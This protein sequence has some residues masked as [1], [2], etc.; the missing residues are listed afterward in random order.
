MDLFLVHCL[1]LFWISLASAR[2][3]AARPADQLLAAGLLAWGNVV[4]T[5]LLLAS[6]HRLGNPAWFFTTSVSLAG[7]V[8]VLLRRLAPEPAGGFGPAETASVGPTH[9]WLAAAFV[10]TLVFLV[11]AGAAIA[12]TYQ[13]NSAAALTWQL[14]RVL[15]YLGQDSLAHFSAADLRQTHLPFNANL[16][17]LFALIYHPPLQALNLLGLL[18]WAGAGLAVHRLCRQSGCGANAALLACWLSLTTLPV[19]AAATAATTQL[20]AAAALLGALVFAGRWREFRLDRDASLA[21]LACG[22]ALGADLAVWLFLP[23]LAI[24][25]IHDRFA[26]PSKPA[27]SM[28][29]R[30]AVPACLLALGT[31]APFLFLDLLERGLRLLPSLANLAQTGS[32]GAGLTLAGFLPLL[33]AP[34]PLVALSE[35]AVGFG[36]G[37]LLVLLGAAGCALRLV[38]PPDPTLARRTWLALGAIASALLGWKWLAP[39]AQ[40]FLPIF[41]ILTPCVAATLEATRRRVWLV[42]VLATV[43]VAQWSAGIYVLRNT[44]R[45]L[46]PLVNAAFAPPAMP[47]LPLLLEHRLS[48]TS[49]INVDTDGINERIFPL[50]ALSEWQRITSHAKLDASAYNLL[51]R[52]SRSRNRAY[53]SPDR[54]PSYCLLALPGK[55]TAGVEFLATVGTGASARDYFGLGPAAGET[56]PIDSNRNVLLTVRHGAGDNESWVKLAGLNPADRARVELSLEHADGQITPVATLFADGEAKVAPGPPFRWLAFRAYDLDS[57]AEIGAAVIP[58]Q[59]QAPEELAPLDPGQATGANSL[60]VTDLVLS[61]DSPLSPSP[62]LLPTEGPFPQWNLPFLRWAREPSVQ[63]KIPAVEKLARVRLSFSARLHVRKKAA[64]AVVW[65]GR[66]VKTYRI[67]GQTTWLDQTLELPAQPGENLLEFR[68]APLENEPDWMD[69]LERYPDV[70]KFFLAQKMPLE[71]SAR[72]HYE[73][74]GRAEGRTI[75]LIARPEPAPDGYYFMFRN[76]RLE[77]FTNP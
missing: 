58:Y 47:T 15:Y 76:I 36:P 49:R 50:L 6:L 75:N 69:Y 22:L 70:K 34:S 55:R 64:L 45:P 1:A 53:G 24:L 4:A 5:G 2:A 11:T 43:A 67:E 59:P 32:A 66:L 44:S 65:N 18:A 21:G 3:L 56:P 9:R 7:L 13:P 71:S 38:R 77:G 33:R 61:K 41:L 68:D 40:S 10:V 26:A 28:T 57:G 27:N 17:Q 16:L 51:S 48:H 73:T 35:D 29:R 37:G 72:E 12:W 74:H 63:I 62:G 25:W 23:P 60:F 52:A 20:P 19:L 42:A 46:L 14:P 54:A 39:D 30:A 8:W 31:G